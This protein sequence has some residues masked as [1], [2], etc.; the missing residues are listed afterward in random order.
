MF[1][2]PDRFTYFKNKR[3]IRCFNYQTVLNANCSLE[4]GQKMVED[5]PGNKKTP[6]ASA[7]FKLEWPDFF[8]EFP[9]ERWSRL[10]FPASSPMSELF[11]SMELGVR[12]A[13]FF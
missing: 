2:I 4:F 13:R 1:E 5:S 3:A 9:N 11:S 12:S 10:T 8:R 6:K 7:C